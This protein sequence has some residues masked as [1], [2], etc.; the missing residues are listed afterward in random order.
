MFKPLTSFKV[1]NAAVP[2][3]AANLLS[4]A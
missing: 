4:N 1:Q 2:M 3:R